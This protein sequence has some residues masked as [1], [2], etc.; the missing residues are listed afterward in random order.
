M[1]SQHTTP[2]PAEHQQRDWKG[3]KGHK[4]VTNSEDDKA[5]MMAKFVEREWREVVRK[6]VEVEQQ[7][8][9]EEV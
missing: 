1:A 2:T 5:D 9:V 4:L 6:A 8:K 3:A 7:W